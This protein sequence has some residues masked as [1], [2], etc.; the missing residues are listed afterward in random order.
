MKMEKLTKFD[1]AEDLDTDELQI[2]YLAE[3][4]K[5]NDP[6]AL[7]KAIA[8]VARQYEVT[9]R[10]C[11]IREFGCILRKERIQQHVQP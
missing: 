9:S 2:L 5:E 3:V 8:T 7:I 6:A 4:A 11:R 1:V 10:F